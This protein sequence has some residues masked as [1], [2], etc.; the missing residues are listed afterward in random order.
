MINWLDSQEFWKLDLEKKQQRRYLLSSPP[1]LAQEKV[2]SILIQDLWQPVESD[3][4]P[5]LATG[6]TQK[7]TPEQIEKYLK[8]LTELDVIVVGGQAINLWASIYAQTIIELQQYIPFSS[9]DLDVYGGRLEAIAC[10]KVLG[11]KLT[12]NKDFDS[13]P[14]SGVLIIPLAE[15]NLRIDFLASVFGLNETEIE[16]TAIQFNT[17]TGLSL[18][19]LHPILCLEGKLKSLLGLP[20]SGRQDLKHLK[21]AILFVNGFISNNLDK[22]IKNSLKLI[23]RIFKN[24]IS[25]KGL[26][27]WFTYDI[28]LES[29]IPWEMI[30]KLPD[31][32]WLN[33]QKTRKPQMLSLIAQKRN[34]Y[35][36]MRN[37]IK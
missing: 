18:K 23:E 12:L 11:G 1:E 3:S 16:E 34:Q 33:F 6:M 20:Q 22:S 30:A 13:S 25:E 19:V 29:A 36:Q 9:E 15:R 27:A 14:N 28:C 10:Q 37:N 4:F 26:S 5:S 35:F 17:V 21:M 8:T 24:T 31:P 2:N 32:K 7:Y